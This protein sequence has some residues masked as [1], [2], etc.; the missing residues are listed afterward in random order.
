MFGFITSFR[1]A[2]LLG[3]ANKR[4]DSRQYEDAL[5]RALMA[6]KLKLS[7]QFEWLAYSIE[8][9]ARAHLGDLENALPALKKAEA[10]LQPIAAARSDSKHLQNIIG[11]VRAYIEKIESG[12][13]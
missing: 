13:A 3:K 12:A 2:L 6:Q 1:A 11:D 7:E 4:L 8:G 9:K 5:E 10:L